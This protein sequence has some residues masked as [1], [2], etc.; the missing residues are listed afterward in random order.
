[1]RGSEACRE[2]VVG[3]KGIP[4]SDESRV[5]GRSGGLRLFPIG[6]VVFCRD[7]LFR[8]NGDAIIFDDL[9]GEF[10]AIGGA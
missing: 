6:A 10:T 1:M 7:W 5:G 4:E 9:I 8:W 3:Q 2:G